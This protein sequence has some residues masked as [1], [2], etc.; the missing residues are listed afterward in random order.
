MCRIIFTIIFILSFFDLTIAQTYAPAIKNDYNL[1]R[2]GSSQDALGNL[3]DYI[4]SVNIK[5][6]P[7]LLIEKIT[8]LFGVPSDTLDNKL[9]WSEISNQDL[10]NRT[11]NFTMKS[12][13]MSI[14]NVE[15]WTVLFFYARNDR[16]QD[17]LRKRSRS[18]DRF[19]TYFQNLVDETYIN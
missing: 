15:E 7:Q 5:E 18:K 1:V 6:N 12:M 17:L 14:P 9:I 2:E 10:S 16:N 4:I 11:F 13:E 3:T 8:G 19:I